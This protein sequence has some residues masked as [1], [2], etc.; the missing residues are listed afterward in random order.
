MSSPFDRVIGELQIVLA[1]GSTHL[2]SRYMWTEGA[3]A[4]PHNLPDPSIGV[5]V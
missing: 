1:H 3:R 4:G 2:G 5:S